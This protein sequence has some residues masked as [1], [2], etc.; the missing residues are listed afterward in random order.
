MSQ[1]LLSGFLAFRLSG[2]SP[3]ASKRLSSY[4]LHRNSLRRK[5]L[6]LQREQACGSFIDVPDERQR[7]AQDRRQPIAILDARFRVLVLDDEV[8][9]GDIERE[10]FS[11]CKLVVE[12]IDGSILEIRERIVSSRPRQLVF[13]DRRLFLP[14]VELFSRLLGSDAAGPVVALDGLAGIAP[15]R[16]AARVD[17]LS[18]HMKSADQEAVTSV[19]E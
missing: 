2:F 18:L 1:L 17:D 8:G 9:I 14:R 13:A 15:R 19:L 7:S 6:V 11:R 10:E 5:D 16:D 4:S 12:P 3:S